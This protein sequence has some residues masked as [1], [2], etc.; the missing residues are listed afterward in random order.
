MPCL[1]ANASILLYFSRFLLD[2]FWTSWSRVKTSWRGLL[3][4]LAPID[5][6]L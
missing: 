6:N 4:L 1:F 3:I 5:L 2:L